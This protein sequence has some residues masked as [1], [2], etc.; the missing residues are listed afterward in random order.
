VQSKTAIQVLSPV[1]DDVLGVVTGGGN[2]KQLTSGLVTRFT[3]PSQRTPYLKGL[4]SSVLQGWADRK[5]RVAGALA[6]KSVTA[7]VG[8]A[9]AAA[10][11]LLNNNLD[12][13][14]T[15]DD[16]NTR[17]SGYSPASSS[18]S[19]DS[20]KPYLYAKYGGVVVRKVATAIPAFGQPVRKAL[21]ML[22]LT[23]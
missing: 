3:S 7:L 14:N 17:T 4:F 22:G 15:H 18:F 10:P 1:T 21:N 5:L 2:A 13:V 19:L 9:V 23:L 12:P 11:A 6:Q 16:F 8:E 20:A